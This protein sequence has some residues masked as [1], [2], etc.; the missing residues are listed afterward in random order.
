MIREH[1][2]KAQQKWVFGAIVVVVLV[3]GIAML[4]RGQRSR[5]FGER[6]V[7]SPVEVSGQSPATADMN[8]GR[9]LS[10]LGDYGRAPAFELVTQDS[11]TLRHSD[12]LGTLWVADFIFTNCASTCP[13]MTRSMQELSDMV[14]PDY[15]VH[16]V[17][18][19]VDP[20]RDTPAVLTRYAQDYGIDTS[21]WT[22][23]TGDKQTLR[24]LVL[25]GFHL[26]VQDATREDLLA[27]ADAVIHSTRF[28]V[29]DPQGVIRGYYDGTDK[30]ALEQLITDLG[31]LHAQT[32]SR[33][34]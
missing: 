31:T 13:L 24:D 10:R 18:F 11:D 32:A 25:N 7:S 15:D 1:R 28:V 20:E 22:F 6:S 9:S 5:L 26:S 17:S 34:P 29:V 12:L 27:G 23:L 2:M 8:G 33:T 19:S 21:N 14:D 4:L 30:E 16:F 3:L